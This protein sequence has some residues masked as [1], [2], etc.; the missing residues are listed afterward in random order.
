MKRGSATSGKE[1]HVEL[2]KLTV[3]KIVDT[4]SN[5][6]NIQIAFEKEDELRFD[7]KIDDSQHSWT[8]ASIAF[9]PDIVLHVEEGLRKYSDVEWSCITDSR[10]IVFEIES[11]PQN[12][13]SNLIKR[14]AYSEI[15]K[16]NRTQYSFVLVCWEDAKL[17]ENISPFDEVWKFHRKVVATK[18]G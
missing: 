6:K 1:E 5:L 17:P 3:K 15:R 2:V 11:N 7:F 16:R 18:K 4:F 14:A 12:F 8:H 13:F 9:R 10:A